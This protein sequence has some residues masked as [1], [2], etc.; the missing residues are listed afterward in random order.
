MSYIEEFLCHLKNKHYSPET[1]KKY[2]SLLCHFKYSMQSSGVSDVKSVSHNEVCEYM[3]EIKKK[4]ISGAEYALMICRLNIHFG[5]IEDNNL[6][7]VS[8]LIDYECPKYTKNHYLALSEQE[9]KSIF[10]KIST[11]HPLCL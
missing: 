8:P 9:I 5:Y 6:I 11:G 3:E 10:E 4:K 2:S 1:V 7:F